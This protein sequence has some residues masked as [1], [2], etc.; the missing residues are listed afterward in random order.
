MDIKRNIKKVIDE[1]SRYF[2]VLVLTGPRQSGKTTFLRT[3]FDTYKY[4]NLENPDIR[5]FALRDPR[6]F[7]SEYDGK[8]I[9]DEVQHVP[10]LF[11]YIQSIVDEKQVMG[12]YVLSGSQNFYMMEKITQSLA[13]R[14][15]IHT[16]FPFDIC[17]L[18]QG[19]LLN[20]DLKTAM[21]QGSFPAVFSRNIP[22]KR[23]YSDSVTTY[24]KS[25]VSQLQNIH[26]AG[27]FSRFIKLC[28]GRAGQL[29]NFNDLAKDAGVSHT[30]AR[31]WLSILE[32]SYIVFTLPSYHKNF[33]KRLIKSPKLYFY[34]TGLLCY[35]LGIS[36]GSFGPFHT[37][38]GNVFENFIISETIKLNHHKNLYREF[39]FWRDSHGHEIDLLF[40]QD[41]DVSIMEIK[42][43]TT[44][45][46]EMTKGLDYFENIS[47]L[48]NLKK[49]LVYGG[50]TSQKRTGFEIVSWNALDTL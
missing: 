48:P 5:D 23:Y 6:V 16:L 36:T 4:I 9:F 11:S 19:G 31:N 40:E 8:V 25:D 29:I 44:I 17:E 33:S 39:Y 13:G 27:L 37:S 26:N 32:T 34:D 22:V 15:G 42:S 20:N 10:P 28:A 50:D 41:G 49:Y 43:S 24:V 45:K 46:S 3:Y 1:T 47:K 18:K 38:Y 35:L 7:L 2:P 30:T 12:D 21:L 14:V